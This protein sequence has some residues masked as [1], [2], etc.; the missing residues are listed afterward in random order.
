MF[1]SASLATKG[2]PN[3]LGLAKTMKAV[4]ILIDGL[5]SENLRFRPGHA[6][7]LNRRLSE[8]KSIDCVFP[9]TTASS[10]TSLLTGLPVGE[11]GIIGYSVFDRSKGAALN[12][13]TGWGGA[14]LPSQYQ[15]ADSIAQQSNETGVR[16]YSVGPAEYENSGF[17]A[18]NNRG[19]HYVAAKTIAERFEAAKLLLNRSE[20]SLIYLY[21]PELDQAAHAYGS[22]SGQWL[23]KLEELDHEVRLFVQSIDNQ[24]AVA[25]TADHGIVNVP[26][27]NQIYL[28]EID[29]PDIL[30]VG[31]DPRATYIYLKDPNS[32]SHLVDSYQQ[33]LGDHAY[34]GQPEELIDKGWFG[35]KVTAQARALMP[36]VFVLART[37]CAFYHRKFSK[38]QSLKMIGQH[39]SV[40]PTEMK[41]PLLTWGAWS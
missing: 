39:G 5:G 34:V 15:V 13:L 19:S 8:T 22:E 41:V 33:H 32:A 35:A 25:L 12:M 26:A 27:S 24:T 38:P 3:P 18:L 20:A 21:V 37:R 31:G 11:H 10:V 16:A 6:P 4:V 1:K 36:D 29:V 17:T 40:S 7:F 23:A 2:S 30:F 28:D 14:F 9:S